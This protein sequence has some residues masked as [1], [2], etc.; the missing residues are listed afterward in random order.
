M[1]ACTKPLLKPSLAVARHFVVACASNQDRLYPLY[2]K[3]YRES[4]STSTKSL[5]DITPPYLLNQL[6]YN[7]DSYLQRDFH[8]DDDY[9]R[10]SQMI[11]RNI[12]Q[13]AASMAS[14][15]DD[16]AYDE[17]YDQFYS[18]MTPSSIENQDHEELESLE[19]V[20]HEDVGPSEQRHAGND[21]I[22]YEASTQEPLSYAEQVEEEEFVEL[23]EDW[24]IMHQNLNCRVSSGTF[25]VCDNVDDVIQ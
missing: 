4:R 1:L 9:E 14:S 6:K 16:I 21:S 12:T 23:E 19:M 5:K 18:H 20:Q 11:P 13:N 17:D 7:S 3:A 2:C 25:E 8:D 24:E 15:Q 10:Y 22:L